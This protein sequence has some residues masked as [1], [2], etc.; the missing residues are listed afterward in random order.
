[1]PGRQDDGAG[2]DQDQDKP[3]LKK[4][5]GVIS[6]VGGAIAILVAILGL[7]FTFF[8]G[9]EP[10]PDPPKLEL[11]DV[12]VAREQDIVADWSDADQQPQPAVNNWTASLLS[13]AL[14][15][16]SADEVLVTKAEF[17]FT[18]VTKLGCPYGG[19]GSVAKARY[20]IKVPASGFTPPS[21]LPRKLKFEVP[22]HGNER[23]T[24]TV[25][26]E[27]YLSGDLPKVYSFTTT[28]SADDGSRLTTEP[29]VVMNPQG[30]KTV[31]QGA[32]RAMRYTDATVKPSCVRE[33]ARRAREIVE[34][35]TLVSPELVQFS[36]ELNRL[37][38]LP[39]PGGPSQ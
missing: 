22:P 9:F 30:V 20:D 11:S 16:R 29:V 25:G 12:D 28:L 32:E 5:Q 6:V 15:N 7:V 17:A 24:F 21:T 19:G 18:A 23:I 2:Q 10:K 34:G 39:D 33:Q 1:M 38:A 31:L 8:P 3:F 37:A 13:I 36:G 26:P 35:A 27:T 14:R 4:P